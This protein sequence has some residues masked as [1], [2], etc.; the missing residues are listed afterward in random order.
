MRK[1][2]TP[3]K[4]GLLWFGAAVSIAE[5]VVGTGLAPLGFNKA[6]AAIIL[7]HIIGGTM[8]FLAGL[9]GARTRRG[10]M[11][12]VKLA[13]GSAG[14]HFFSALNITQLVGWTAVMIALGAT[15]MKSVWQSPH[16]A[17]LGLG[18]GI[19]IAMWIYVGKDDIAKIS[20][21]TMSAM[22]G[23]CL[24]ASKIV[25][26][27]GGGAAEGAAAAATAAEGG[28]TFAQAVE[29]SA[30]MPLSWLPLISDYTRDARAK[31]VRTT[32]AGVLVYGITSCWMYA[33]GVG[34]ALYAGGEEIALVMKNAGFGIAAVAIIVASTVT[35]TFMDAFSAGV[36]AS[37][38]GKRIPEKAAALTVCAI[39]TIAAMFADTDKYHTFLYFIGS[40]FAP[41]IAVQVAD[42]FIING[43][44][45]PE[46]SADKKIRILPFAAWA[47][48]FAAYHAA[49]H[50]DITTPLGLAAPI[51]AFTAILYCAANLCLP[52]KLRR[53]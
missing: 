18:L 28:I 47:S 51:I 40:V 27:G 9:I 8:M 21:V 20:L 49:L 42:Y 2:T 23:L 22:F 41:M 10:A 50:Y 34:L 52:R 31:P 24:L 1:E 48:G 6:L 17:T 11:E 45:S 26:F 4:H 33:L 19:L 38:I 39:G 16:P 53:G 14:G 44:K 5:I 35:T 46:D 36:S 12:T 15:A 3:L 7:G 30:V 13:F 29:L 32:L 43:K 25:F 37:S